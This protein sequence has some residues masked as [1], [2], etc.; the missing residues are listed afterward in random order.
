MHKYMADW[1]CCATVPFN[2][3]NKKSDNFVEKPTRL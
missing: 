2:K 1:V 3:M